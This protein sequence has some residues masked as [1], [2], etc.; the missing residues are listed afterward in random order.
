M[1]RSK[2]LTRVNKHS[3]R[4]KRS[5]RPV[6]H[7]GDL[8]RDGSRRGRWCFKALVSVLIASCALVVLEPSATAEPNSPI[9][10]DSYGFWSFQRLGYS[11]LDVPVSEVSQV[12]VRYT[13][14]NGAKQGPND[15]Y[16]IHLH[17]ALELAESS[18]PGLIYVDAATNGAAS[19]QITVSFAI[20]GGLPK[21]TLGSVS[22]GEGSQHRVLD[23]RRADI[24]Y[25][26]YLQ[27]SGVKEG[28][29]ILTIKLRQ[30]TDA[31]LKSLL[32]FS[33]DSGIEFTNKS[34]PK[35]EII[36]QPDANTIHIG[37]EVKINVEVRNTSAWSVPEVAVDARSDESALE[38]SGASVERLTMS[39]GVAQRSF[40][41]T[42]R[43]S[44]THRIFVRAAGGEQRPKRGLI[45]T[46]VQ[47]LSS[48]PTCWRGLP[49]SEG[50]LSWLSRSLGSG[51]WEF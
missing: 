51:C 6:L 2:G 40:V 15:W 23:S 41:L 28:G 35:L 47:S 50:G 36:I 48:A 22:L 13:L 38:L 12:S 26:N 27:F 19:A 34:P 7:S 9:A 5:Q 29:N 43:K 33:A 45:F 39:N 25:S 14:P 11:D 8:W 16:L 44:G 24:S 17:V 3:L 49:S 31:R 21:L 37:Q 4:V 46:L 42:A 32:V 18:A 10:V 20:D 30:I 1:R